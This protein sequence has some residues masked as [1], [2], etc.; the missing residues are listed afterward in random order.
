MGV[1]AFQATQSRGQY[2][3][4]SWPFLRETALAVLA[5]GLVTLSALGLYRPQLLRGRLSP[6]TW[7]ALLAVSSLLAL[8]TLV[9]RPLAS[10]VIQRALYPVRGYHFGPFFRIDHEWAAWADVPVRWIGTLDRNRIFTQEMAGEQGR[11]FSGHWIIMGLGNGAI[12]EGIPPAVFGP[13]TEAGYSLLFY[14]PPQ[15]G[16]SSGVRTRGSDF[17]AAEVLI[18]SLT[19]RGAE[20]GNI[21]LLGWSIG[22]GMAVEMMTRYRLGKSLLVVPL[23]RVDSIARRMA[24]P[25]GWAAQ[26]IIGEKFEYDNVG[27][28]A[29]LLTDRVVI[30]QGARDVLMG[31][32]PPRDADQM[33]NVWL[34][35]HGIEEV[36]EVGFGAW[37]RNGRELIFQSHAGADHNGVNPIDLL[38]REYVH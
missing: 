3:E 18:Q 7:R 38:I 17:L 2:E 37:E 36:A 8:R 24:G 23:G 30:H 33:R 16:Q 34:R 21:H 14:H 29:R 10:S 13:L 4:S 35:A 31:D 6:A 1:V 11:R 22:S 26:G 27:K 19:G 12:H 15:Y 9:C 5:A 20:E 28:M 32:R 25:L